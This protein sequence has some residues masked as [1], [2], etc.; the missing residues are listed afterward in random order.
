MKVK[1][2]VINNK[3]NDEDV[4]EKTIN[5]MLNNYGVNPNNIISCIPMDNANFIW[6][7]YK[8]E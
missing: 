8:E 2:L 4:T 6:I 3:G 7:S 5:Q 1:I